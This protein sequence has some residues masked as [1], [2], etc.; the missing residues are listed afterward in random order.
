[1]VLSNIC[2]LGSNV[3]YL[4]F[5]VFGTNFRSHCQLL[6]LFDLEGL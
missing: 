2:V 5:D 3:Q 1:M 6:C 4:V